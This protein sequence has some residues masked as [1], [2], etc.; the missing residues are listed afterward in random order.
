MKATVCAYR[1]SRRPPRGLRNP[2]EGALLEERNRTLAEEQL[3]L[4]RERYQV[5]AIN[6]VD[7]VEA[8][9]VLAQAERDRV[10]AVYAYHD[11]ITSLEAAVGRP[12]RS[13]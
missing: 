2:R 6:F 1:L 13:R 11:A 9:T 10:A 4:A 7:L 5:G 12:L 3:R 8:E